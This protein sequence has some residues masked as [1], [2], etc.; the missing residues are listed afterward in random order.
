MRGDKDRKIALRAPADVYERAE[1]V[2]ES[3]SRRSLGVEVST[4]EVLRRALLHGLKVL[5]RRF[6]R[7]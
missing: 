3:I 4:S 7:R 5:E 2:R 1:R 6:R